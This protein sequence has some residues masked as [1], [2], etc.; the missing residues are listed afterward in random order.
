M[1]SQEDNPKDAE[2]LILKIDAVFK[3]YCDFIKEKKVK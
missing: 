1:E 2:E 3:L